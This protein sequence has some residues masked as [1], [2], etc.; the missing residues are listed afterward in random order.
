MSLKNSARIPGIACTPQHFHA[1]MLMGLFPDIDKHFTAILTCVR[2]PCARLESEF[3]YQRAGFNSGAVTQEIAE[4]SAWAMA[5][6]ECY[7]RDPFVFGNHFRPQWQFIVPGST[8]FRMENDGV[9]RMVAFAAKNLG[10]DHA[11]AVECHNA[12]PRTLQVSWSPRLRDRFVRTYERDFEM[13]GYR[14]DF[15]E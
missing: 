8:I 4:F 5:C 9:S 10:L 6:L 14:S 2:N 3:H 12:S 11:P 15:G 7:D 1:S 13:F